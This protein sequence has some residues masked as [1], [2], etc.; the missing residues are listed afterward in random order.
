MATD[1]SETDRPNLI[2]STIL[3]GAFRLFEFRDD[4]HWF[5]SCSL[6]RCDEVGDI[7]KGQWHL[8]SKSC[9]RRENAIG[10]WGRSSERSGSDWH[11]KISNGNSHLVW[12]TMGTCA[13]F[14]LVNRMRFVLRFEEFH[15]HSSV[16]ISFRIMEVELL[17]RLE[18]LTRTN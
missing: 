5:P 17:C 2:D 16:S 7:C 13:F 4:F 14:I 12:L 11:W 3:D 1:S 9:N 8:A 6:N 10:T 18:C 15:K